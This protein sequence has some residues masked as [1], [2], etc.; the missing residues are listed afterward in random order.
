M[1]NEEIIFIIILFC[2]LEE[3]LKST[4]IKYINS[5]KWEMMKC[6]KEQN[7]Q[8]ICEVSNKIMKIQWLNDIIKFDIDDLDEDIEFFGLTVHLNEIIVSIYYEDYETEKFNILLYSLN[9]KEKLSSK[10]ISTNNAF[11]LANNNILPV[12]MNNKD[13]DYLLICCSY[14]CDFIDNYED[15]LI[16]NYKLNKKNYI[17]HISIIS[18]LFKLNDNYN[19]FYGFIGESGIVVS[20]LVVVNKFNFSNIETNVL[21]IIIADDLYIFSCFQT[22]NNIIE[23]MIIDKDNQLNII[24]FK[25]DNLNLIQT[26][27]LDTIKSIYTIKCIHL[28][29]EIG[30]YNYFNG[31]DFKSSILLIKNLIYNEHEEIYKINDIINDTIIINLSSTNEDLYINIDMLK[32]SE[33]RFSILYCLGRH[34]I[35]LILCDLFGKEDDK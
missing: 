31:N 24:L 2:L 11:F 1:K 35:V 8:K 27:N 15:S 14:Y 21:D 28:Q 13:E 23:C 34:K 7:E 9:D 30:V 12:K 32:I 6:T 25:E 20:A 18:T 22:E 4:P 26:I 19:Y 3:C 5:G 17:A 29:K 16:L 33:K 10:I